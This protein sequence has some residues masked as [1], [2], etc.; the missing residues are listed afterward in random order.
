MESAHE[1]QRGWGTCGFGFGWISRQTRFT[2]EASRGWRER[3]SLGEE[4]GKH[5]VSRT[6]RRTGMGKAACIGLRIAV[7]E[8]PFTF[9]YMH[10]CAMHTHVHAHIE[11]VSIEN[12]YN[13]SG[14]ATTKEKSIGG[15]AQT[16][17]HT[18][19]HDGVERAGRDASL[20]PKR[21]EVVRKSSSRGR[22]GKRKHLIGSQELLAQ[23]RELQVSCT[24]PPAV[25]SI[26]SL[27]SQV[28]STREAVEPK[29]TRARRHMCRGPRTGAEK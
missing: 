15:L 8:P 10:T 28:T 16:R 7:R 2:A 23:A 18:Y 29:E 13:T 27:Q 1:R 11:C 3:E 14:R 4:R 26:R 24:R 21:E 9:P 12:A 5:R 17:A 22:E 25:A 20:P 6:G 19:A